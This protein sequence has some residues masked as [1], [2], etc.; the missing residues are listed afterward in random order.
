MVWTAMRET[1]RGLEEKGVSKRE[2]AGGTN[3]RKEFQEEEIVFTAGEEVRSDDSGGRNKGS[4]GAL[5]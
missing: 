5:R 2:I 1:E 4:K 3:R